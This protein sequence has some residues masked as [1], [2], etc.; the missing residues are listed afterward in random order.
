M[1]LQEPNDLLRLI[2]SHKFHNPLS[3][4]AC[5]LCK[6]E[7]FR[8]GNYPEAMWSKALVRVLKPPMPVAVMALAIGIL[9]AALALTM[10]T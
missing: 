7:V 4:K 9:I 8:Q 6:N 3:P 2:E 1:S 5:Q 10:N